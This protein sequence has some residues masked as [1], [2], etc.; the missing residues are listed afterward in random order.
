MLP[1]GLVIVDN[2]TAQDKYAL[3]GRGSMPT[4]IEKPGF[5]YS[6]PSVVPPPVKNEGHKA[7]VSVVLIVAAVC[8]IIAAYTAADS[9]GIVLHHFRTPIIIEGNWLVGEHRTCIMP[10]SSVELA[11]AA[12]IL[13]PSVSE[14]TKNSSDPFQQF[15]GKAL[16]PAQANPQIAFPWSS[17]P[18]LEYSGEAHIFDVKYWGRIDR[19][20]VATK[21]R[22]QRSDRSITCWALN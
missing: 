7:V 10:V 21:W 6:S 1:S 14:Q 9:A 22:C 5:S 16:E 4:G 2:A 17:F 19:R 11:C 20:G 15:G 13:H 3:Q 12:T 18:A 8:A